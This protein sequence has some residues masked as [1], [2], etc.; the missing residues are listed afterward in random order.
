MPAITRT[1]RIARYG[2][3]L[4][5]RRIHSLGPGAH[6]GRG[7]L[8][9]PSGLPGHYPSTNSSAWY[10]L[11]TKGPLRTCLNPIARASPRSA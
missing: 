3:S 10:E 1:T 4:A 7:A 2:S 6:L 11:R 9:R 5:K 8:G